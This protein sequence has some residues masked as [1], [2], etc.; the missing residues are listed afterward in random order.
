MIIKIFSVHLEE[1]KKTDTSN[2]AF[3]A[4][5]PGN[6]IPDPLPEAY[7]CL[8]RAMNTPTNVSRS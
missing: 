8:W 4:V 1:S 5:I 7:V 3:H 6:T 2:L